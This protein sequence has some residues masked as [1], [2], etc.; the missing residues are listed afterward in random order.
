M[1]ASRYGASV[2]GN[3]V[4]TLMVSIEL[5]EPPRGYRHH[6]APRFALD[7]LHVLGAKRQHELPRRPLHFD[8]RPLG[9]VVDL[10]H[11]AERFVC[12][13]AHRPADQLLLVDFALLE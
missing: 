7:L 3:S 12:L 2:S 5:V 13:V 9:E 8:R 10:A 11:D 1:L 4:T 6:Q